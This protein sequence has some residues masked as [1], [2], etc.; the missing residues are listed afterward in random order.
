MLLRMVL[1]TH[2]TY[3]H[4]NDEPRMTRHYRT[5]PR[6]M[7]IYH[8]FSRVYR[9]TLV[10]HHTVSVE[11]GHRILKMIARGNHFHTKSYGI[12]SRVECCH[13]FLQFCWCY[14][15]K[16]FT[17]LYQKHW[18]TAYICLSRLGWIWNVLCE[19]IGWYPAPYSPPTAWRSKKTGRLNPSSIP[20]KQRAHQSAFKTRPQKVLRID[21]SGFSRAA[22]SR[23]F[24]V[25]EKIINVRIYNIAEFRA[26]IR[27]VEDPWDATE[28]L[29]KICF[30]SWSWPR[31]P[32]NVAGWPL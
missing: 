3:I 6:I 14:I 2:I 12:N 31:I 5:W 21:G 27:Y 8:Y 26:N 19:Q 32:P 23:G 9:E 1:Q 10:K 30:F 29:Q 16:Y 7:I 18:N 28:T 25:F 20:G 15:F 17:L 22:K 24:F 11:S 13:R 4:T